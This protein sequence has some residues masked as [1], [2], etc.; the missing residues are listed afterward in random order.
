[1]DQFAAPPVSTPVAGDAGAG[2]NAPPAVRRG[3][4]ARWIAAELA[5]S[6]AARRAGFDQR[7]YADDCWLDWSL[8]RPVGIGPEAPA[9]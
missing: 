2:D 9:I 4:G 6:I 1:M 5:A 7:Q 8:I 3:L